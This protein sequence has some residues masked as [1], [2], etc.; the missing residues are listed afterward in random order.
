EAGPG[1]ERAMKQRYL[2]MVLAGL[3]SACA[4]AGG[5]QTMES[6][7]DGSY[8]E[9]VQHL[10]SVRR[11]QVEPTSPVRVIEDAYYMPIQAVQPSQQ[12]DEPVNCKMEFNPVTAAS[13]QEIAQAISES[14]SIR[15][16]ITNDAHAAV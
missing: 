1:Q 6:T 7:V 14:C 13:L 5:I 9:A 15:V 16:R 12:A 10:D 8:G 4:S 3:L 11:G 2:P